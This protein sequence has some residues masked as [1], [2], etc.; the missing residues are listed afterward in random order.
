MVLP[1]DGRFVTGFEGT[2]VLSEYA[3]GSE[4]RAWKL[5]LEEAFTAVRGVGSAVYAAD[6]NGVTKVALE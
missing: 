6:E 3:V 1:A 5:H 4:R 2:N